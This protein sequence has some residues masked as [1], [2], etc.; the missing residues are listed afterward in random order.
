[1]PPQSRAVPVLTVTDATD[2]SFTCIYDTM[3][4]LT[5]RRDGLNRQESYQ[6]ELREILQRFRIAKG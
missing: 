2:Q 5:T 3:D 6:Y 1:M 4:R